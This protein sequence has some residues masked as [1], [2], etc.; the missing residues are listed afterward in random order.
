VGKKTSLCL[1]D[2]RFSRPTASIIPLDDG[3]STH[4]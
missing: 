1:R 2:F 4:L 3:G